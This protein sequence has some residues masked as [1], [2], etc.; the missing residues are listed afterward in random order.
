MAKQRNTNDRGAPATTAPT[1][2][3]R[4]VG[5]DTYFETL[6]KYHKEN[7][8]QALAALK[9]FIEFKRANPLQQAGGKDRPYIGSGPLS[10]YIHAGLTRDIS[11]V[12]TISG[13]DPHVIKLFGLYTHQDTG[14]G[15][16]GRPNLSKV[17]AA[18]WG[19]QTNFTPISKLDETA[20]SQPALPL[21]Q[22]LL[23]MVEI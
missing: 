9:N 18:T 19:K 11:I 4:F 13:R 1:R 20:T 15:T 10:G 12:Y 6:R 2:L 23:E 22:E 16:P 7:N 5:A 14:T 3:V 8:D 21:L 17:M